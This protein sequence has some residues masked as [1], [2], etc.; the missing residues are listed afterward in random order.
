M[1]TTQL[2]LDFSEP[3]SFSPVKN[4]AQIIPFPV[5]G[6]AS[7]P[8]G[9]SF[10]PYGAWLSYGKRLSSSE[11]LRK[12]QK[13]IA[14]L[15]KAP[16]QLTPADI[17]TIRSYSGWGGLSASNERGVLYDYYTSP[18]IAAFVWHL[19]DSIKPIIKNAKI[20]EPSCGTGVFFAAG[21]KDVSFTGVEL[22]K[23]TAAVAA[24]L[25]PNH[26]ILNKSYEAFNLSD[27]SAH[28][29]LADLD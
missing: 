7:L 25:H 15:S 22:D 17:D 18:P 13:A 21:P 11:R 10:P 4:T 24:I 1:S 23:R 3:A 27:C 29:E 5:D 28:A 19:L 14:L 8:S 12:N 26:S 20:L 9:F 6:H 16:E 2:W